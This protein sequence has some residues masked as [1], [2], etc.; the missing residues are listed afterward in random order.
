MPAEFRVHGLAVDGRCSQNFPDVLAANQDYP[1]ESKGLLGSARQR[2]PRI[3]G[4]VMRNI[5]LANAGV[6]RQPSH[7]EIRA[8]SKPV[9]AEQ[10]GF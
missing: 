6:L 8:S 10:I 3:A 2:D 9:A 5:L 1:D 7:S 4:S